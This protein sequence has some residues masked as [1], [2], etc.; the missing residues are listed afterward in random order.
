MVTF[1]TESLTTTHWVAIV[2]AAITGVIHLAIG[3]G[4]LPSGLAISFVLAGLGFFGAITLVLL[5]YRRRLLYAVGIPFTATQIVLWFVL[6]GFPIDATEAV[7]KAAQV[8]LI[9]LL[10]VLFRRE[11]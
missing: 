8:G 7:D 11:S 6:N 10:A 2:L 9:I 3:I 1:E 4:D 5:N